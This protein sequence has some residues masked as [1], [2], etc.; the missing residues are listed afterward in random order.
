MRQIQWG[1]ILIYCSLES[2]IIEYAVY[3]FYM[4]LLG[5]ARSAWT[6]ALSRKTPLFW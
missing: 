6:P 1:V 2:I 5:I 3:Y 4:K